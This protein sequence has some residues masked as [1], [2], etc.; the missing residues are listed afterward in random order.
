MDTPQRI[1]DVERMDSVLVV[2]PTINLSDLLFEGLIEETQSLL[3]QLQDPKVEGVIV[4]LRHTTYFGTD[5]ISVLLKLWKRIR[6]KG[7]RMALC[8]ISPGEREVL[9]ICELDTIWPFH[10]SLEDA[11]KSVSA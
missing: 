5:F 6:G 8:N 11:L 3:D 10:D 7:G 2:L 9:A 1:F 4:D